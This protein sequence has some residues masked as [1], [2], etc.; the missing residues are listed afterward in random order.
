MKKP[1]IESSWTE[2][3]ENFEA[4]LRPHVMQEFIGQEHIHERLEVYIGAAKQRKETL[5]HCLFYGPP[6]LGKTTLANILAK[7]MGTHLVVTSGPVIEKAGDLAGILTNLKEGDILFIDE[8]HRLPRVVEEYL[9]PAL[10]DFVL[11]LII[12][13]GPN[14]RSVQVK[15]NRFTLVGATTRIGLLSS[16]MRSRFGLSLRLDYYTPESLQ[17]II[18]RSGQILKVEIDPAG[19]MQIAQRSRGTPRIANNL[20]RWTRDYAQMRHNNRIDEACAQKAL[21]MLSIDHKGFDEMDK[22]ILTLLIDAYNGG[23]VGLQTLAIGIGEEQSTVAEVYEPYLIMQGFL[24]RTPRGR[25]A[26]HLAYQHLGRKMPL[27]VGEQS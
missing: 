21:G 5:G 4:V 11:D 1:F 2:P 6:G 22:K 24:K 23:P 8:I 3:D 16:P 18:L 27:N 14:A 15:L 7:A 13:S 17:K 25:E 19:A 26:T 10:E 9:Y 20:L 12:D